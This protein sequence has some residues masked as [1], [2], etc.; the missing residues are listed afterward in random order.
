M[1]AAVMDPWQSGCTNRPAATGV[2]PSREPAVPLNGHRAP[3]VSMVMNCTTPPLMTLRHAY[4]F[5]I[6]LGD[7]IRSYQGLDRVVPVAGGGVSHFVGEPGVGDIDEELDRWVAIAS[8][9]R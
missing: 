8:G 7:A 4:D 3:P 6:T 2:T 5:G 1:P 9:P